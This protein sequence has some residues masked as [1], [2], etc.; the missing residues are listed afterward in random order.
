ML[1]FV[2]IFPPEEW[3]VPHHRQGWRG[4]KKHPKG[5]GAALAAGELELRIECGNGVVAAE[6]GA[7]Q[8]LYVPGSPEL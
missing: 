7:V 5:L 8:D 2:D 3:F 6:H 1:I 4:R